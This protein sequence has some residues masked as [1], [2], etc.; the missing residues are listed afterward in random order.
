[1]EGCVEEAGPPLDPG[2]SHFNH[3]NQLESGALKRKYI[4]SIYIYINGH[5]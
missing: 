3:R 1:M 4:Y 2:R 5:T